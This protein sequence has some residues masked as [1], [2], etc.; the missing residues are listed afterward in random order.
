MQAWDKFLEIKHAQSE[1]VQDLLNKLV[2]D[3]RSINEK[4]A[5]YINSLSFNHELTSF[6]DDDGDE[7]SSI[8][9]KDIIIS[10]LPSVENLVLTPSESEDFSDIE[11]ECD[12]SPIDE[13]V[14]ENTNSIPPG[15]KI[16]CFNPESDLLESLL[17]RDSS[18]DSS[19]KIN[20]LLDEFGGELTRLQSI[21]PGVDNINLD[22]E[23]D[24]LFLEKIDIF[25]GPDDSIPP[26]IE[27]DDFDSKDEDNSAFLPEFELFH[28]DY[29]YS[30]DSTM[31]VV[32][33]ILVDVPNILPSHPALLIDFDFIP[34][35]NDPGS[36][37]DDSSSSGDRNKIYDSG[38]CIEVESTR[39]L[40]TL[41]PVIDTLLPFSSENDD[42]VFNHC[43]LAYKDKSSPSLSHRG[44]QAFQLISDSQVLIHGD[45]TPSLG[46]LG[47]L[48]PLGF[49]LHSPR[50]SHLQL[51]FG[52]SIS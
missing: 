41:S 24:I 25:S 3:V 31:D 38:I 17:N 14:L 48:K 39:I 36:N 49:V 12:V 44:F 43:V 6:Y 22:S 28:N 34:S 50:A 30:G 35:H 33:D 46:I 20:F 40:A 15:I 32:E 23:G 47:C 45:N 7:E 10:E 16:S 21:P 26:G 11:S 37:L 18:I 42:K 5:D 52:N 19:Q 2:E 9:L 4:L 29:P 8:P 1:E 13:E 51:H 27:N